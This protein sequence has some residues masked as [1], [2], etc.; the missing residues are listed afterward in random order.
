MKKKKPP[1]VCLV[2]EF[3]PIQTE[4]HTVINLWAAAGTKFTHILGII[5]IFGK[6]LVRGLDTLLYANIVIIIT[7][8]PCH[9]SAVVVKRQYCGQ[10][11]D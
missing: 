9:S 2:N 1:P 10:S 11:S 3:I 6:P 7:M 5:R 8:T 4:T